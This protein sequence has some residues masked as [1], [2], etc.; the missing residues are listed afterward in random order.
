MRGTGI[1][2]ALLA[3]VALPCAAF[4]QE[5]ATPPSDADQTAEDAV[6][7]PEEEALPAPAMAESA[8]RGNVIEIT[9]GKRDQI[10]QEISAA[11]TVTSGEAIRR[12][13]IRD[14]ADLAGLVPALRVSPDL[15][16]RG[17]A[18]GT[19]GIGITPRIAVLVDGVERSGTAALL[20]D[21]PDSRRVEVLTGPQTTLYG[22]NASAGV[23][24]VITREPQFDFGG[25]AE[26]SYG[27]FNALALRAAITGPVSQSLAL[28][29]SAGLD[30]RDLAQRNRW[31]LRGQA[32][33]EASP[34][35]R[36]RLIA[37]FD[38]ID[39]ICCT[40]TILVPSAA[41]AVIR[42]I[43]GLDGQANYAA[44]SRE[45]NGGLSAQLDYN[46]G[47]IRLT[48]ISAWRRSTVA[49]DQDG[50][51][52]S[53]DLL[54][55][56][57]TDLRL[58]AITQE[59]RVSTNFRFP[60][61]LV[62]G[63]LW[64][65]TRSEQTGQ[66]RYGSQFRQFADLQFRAASAGSQTLT[67]VETALAVSAGS[68]FM[69][70]TGTAE[71]YALNDRS[72]SLFGQ[73]DF[74]VAA[75]LTLTGGVNYTHDEKSYTAAAASTDSFAGLALPAS[76]AALRQFQ[77]LP[78]FTPVPNAAEPGSSSE[79]ATSYTARLSWDLSEKVRFYGS[80]ATG[81]RPSSINLSRGSSL[82]A[83]RVA[84]PEHAALYEVG[85]K[86]DWD[87]VSA[88]LA[89]FRQTIDGF[90]ARLYTGLGY[91]LVNAGQ[92]SVNGVEFEGNVRPV[93]PVQLSLSVVWLDPE[94]DPLPGGLSGTR[95]A[96]IPALS[97]TWGLGYTHRLASGAALIL[98]GDFHYESAAQTA[99]VQ[100]GLLV[101]AASPAVIAAAQA[102]RREASD[103]NLSL[104]RAN[105]GGLEISIWARNLLNTRRYAV[106]FDAPLQP[107][108]V[109]GYQNPPRTWGLSARMAF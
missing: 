4:A 65:D 62:L 98:R 60:V 50:D 21:L 22:Q 39:D 80:Y 90:Q 23:I 76:L 41:T 44:Q 69:A 75:G 102:L 99:E 7:P 106:L 64:S 47:P 2:A 84:G 97:A 83:G 71:V 53:A 58:R 46:L 87:R 49:S 93:D 33:L 72:Y 78:P 51:Q 89:A 81:F 59:F 34:A 28:E 74:E 11:V 68:L 20:G 108:A 86:A 91:V 104:T 55:R 19:G 57:A 56:N 16:I 31:F 17:I 54:A 70:G 67:G 52:T 30:R 1:C 15:R 25:S 36:L 85:I 88:N 43:G 77:F 3:A 45:D 12:A 94:Y 42:A 73:V 14:L 82:L 107:S 109:S 8:D 96:G 10:L 18:G 92:I 27:N 37:D 26:A 9:A 5:A 38:R 6:F 48:S 24:N 105:A 61:Q 66:L 35:L 63:A 100:P 79:H 101:P 103:L 95:P 40:T 13:Q 32:L 29:L